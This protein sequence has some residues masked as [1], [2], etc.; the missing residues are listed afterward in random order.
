MQMLISFCLLDLN[1]FMRFTALVQ[2]SVLHDVDSRAPLTFNEFRLVF[3]CFRSS[4]ED[5]EDEG[6]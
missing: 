5:E 3:F 1:V 4:R 6:R 2:A